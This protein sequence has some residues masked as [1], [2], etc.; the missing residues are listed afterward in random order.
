MKKFLS[1][2]NQAAANPRSELRLLLLHMVSELRKIGTNSTLE[3][4]IAAG[5]Q[6]QDTK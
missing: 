5:R 2:L 6:T 4:A 1:D 3:S